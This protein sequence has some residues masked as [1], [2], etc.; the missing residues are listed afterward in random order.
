M[1]IPLAKM[2]PR[3]GITN[4]DLPEI[5]VQAHNA[6]EKK[7][8]E[9]LLDGRVAFVAFNFFEDSPGCL[10]SAVQSGI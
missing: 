6:W 7:A 4:Q 5:M 2:F 9:A 1:T 3:L 10:L 8:P